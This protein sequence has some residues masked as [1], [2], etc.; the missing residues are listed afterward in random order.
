LNTRPLIGGGFITALSVPLIAD[1]GLTFFTGLTAVG[2]MAMIVWGLRR[3]AKV[4]GI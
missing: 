1:L 3:T 2:S 4:R